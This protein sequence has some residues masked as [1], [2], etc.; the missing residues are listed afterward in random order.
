[1]QL[2]IGA[3][4]LQNGPQSL[5]VHQGFSLMQLKSISQ[6]WMRNDCRYAQKCFLELLF[7][8]D[9]FL[10]LGDIHVLERA[11][12]HDSP[13]FTVGDCR[14]TPNRRRLNCLSTKLPAASSWDQTSCHIRSSG[15]KLPSDPSTWRA[16]APNQIK[17]SQ[18]FSMVSC[19]SAARP[20]N[21]SEI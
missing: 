11:D 20:A 8:I 4:P 7:N 15:R 3:V 1:M 5:A 18:S 10:Q 6:G 12:F 14:R 19:D 21:A 17:F 13:L 16:G 2:R 9:E